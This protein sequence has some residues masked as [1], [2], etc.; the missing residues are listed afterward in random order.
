MQT[1]K[2]QVWRVNVLID[3]VSWSPKTRLLLLPLQ[4]YRDTLHRPHQT[5]AAARSS[6]EE[7]MLWAETGETRLG[8]QLQRALVELIREHL[9]FR[10]ET[11]SIERRSELEIGARFDLG[12]G[13]SGNEQ[14]LDRLEIGP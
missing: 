11:Q 6:I 1:L 5:E 14:T 13:L 9:R 10:N 4:E 3:E 8:R 12:S 7:L 2:R